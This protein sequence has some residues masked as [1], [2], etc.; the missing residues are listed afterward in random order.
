MP[1]PCPG[2]SPIGFILETSMEWW[3]MTFSNARFQSAKAAGLTAEQVPNLKLKWAFGFPGADEV[4]GQ[5]TVAGWARFPRRG[6][7]GGLFHRRGDRLCLLVLPGGCG[8]AHRNQHWA[9]ERKRRS[10][11][12]HLLWRHSG[13][14]LHAGRLHRQR[15]LESESGRSPCGKNYG[16]A[17]A[18][19]RSPVRAG[20][21]ARGAFGRLEHGVSLLHVSRKRCLCADATNGHTIW[22]T[23]PVQDPPKPTTK[24]SNGVQQYGPNGGAVWN[25]PTIDAKN[26]AIYLSLVMLVT[27]F[28][29]IP[30]QLR[31]IVLQRFEVSFTPRPL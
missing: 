6:H 19:R 18:V 31:E 30:T 17:D 24:N 22:K 1:N 4:F 8:S 29:R 9:R 15:N 27:A 26:H 10:Q 2:N 7:R 25:T 21:I 16:R 23:Y 13:Q 20:F 11:I 12:W 14:R 3:A 28:S 5:P